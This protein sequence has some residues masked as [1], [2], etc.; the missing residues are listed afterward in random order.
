MHHFRPNIPHRAAAAPYPAAS[1]GWFLPVF[2]FAIFACTAFGA[3]PAFSAGTVEQIFIRNA[4]NS[5]IFRMDLFGKG[6]SLVYDED[7]GEPLVSKR[8]FYTNEKEDIVRGMVYWTEVLKNKGTLP[9][10][11]II[12]MGV[13]QDTDYNAAAIFF[14]DNKNRGLMLGALTGKFNVLHLAGLT[15]DPIPGGF[16]SLAFINDFTWDTQP[17]SNLPE[18]AGTL[19]PTIIHELGHALGI[20]GD[21]EAFK[22]LLSGPEHSVV[23]NGPKAMAVYGGPVPMA[24]ASDQ[25]DSH[26]GLRNGLMTHCQIPNYPMFMEAELATL[27]DIGY[28]IDLRNFFGR[29]LYGLTDANGVI[30]ADV[31]SYDAGKVIDNN[32]GFFQSKG[33]DENGNWLGYADGR[34]NTSSFGVGLHFYGSYWDVTQQAHLLA[35]GPGGAGIRMDGF[36]NTVNIPENIIISGNGERGTGLLVSFGEHHVI[37]SMGTIMATGNMGIAARFDFG[38]PYVDEKLESYG[39]YYINHQSEDSGGPM[40]WL[41]GPLVREFNL[42]GA[43]IGGPSS[44]DGQFLSGNWENFAG[45]P[46]ALY[47]G[48]SAHVAEIN[49]MNGA[50]IHGDIVSR[51][52]PYQNMNIPSG[53]EWLYMTDLTF[54]YSANIDG[55]ASPWAD[56]N[57]SLNYQGNIIGPDSLKLSHV[58]GTLRYSGQMDVLSYTMQG[59]SSKLL[60]D[61][62][63]G[64]PTSISAPDIT[65]NAGTSIGFSPATFAYGSPLPAGKAPVLSLKATTLDNQATLLNPTASGVFAIGPWEYVYRGI[66]WNADRSTLLVNTSPAAFNHERGGTDAQAAPMALFMH[67]QPLNITSNRIIRRFTQAQTGSLFSEP[68]SAASLLGK[69]P[70]SWQQFFAYGAIPGLANQQK[71]LQTRSQDQVQ[72]LALDNAGWEAKTG[73]SGT[74][75]A[76]YY[77]TTSHRGKRHYTV[78]GAGVAFGMDHQFSESFYLGAAMALDYPR[79]DSSHA[80]VRAK[81]RAGIIYG[82]LVLPCRLEL[83]FAGSMGAIDF[84]Q[85]R[86]VLGQKYETDF[87][88]QTINTALSLGRQFAISDSLVLR[89]ALGWE[90]FYMTRPSHSEG[91]G[92]YALT[93]D[94]SRTSANRLKAGLETAW[95]FGQGDIT[96]RA[97]WLGI[98]DN[99]NEKSSAHFALD[100]ARNTFQAPLDPLDKHSLELAA[101]CNYQLGE[102]IRIGLEYAIVTGERST[103]HQG[104]LGLRFEF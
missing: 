43:L 78:E 83:G 92:P 30:I 98:P 21:N 3:L 52:D 97:F 11:A 88:A 94:S 35:D 57:F 76:P 4:D 63:K 89:P 40:G 10:P 59:T 49:I 73:K 79:Y 25:E 14:A 64:L 101:N 53:D 100:P 95:T 60:V 58:G 16:H 84:E 80:K 33:L 24:H 55:S 22:L 91:T 32:T 103:T 44:P 54:G 29:S 34:P 50:S 45:R 48:P 2:F 99:T 74:W 81:S 68:Q 85:D 37:N 56:Q 31:D 69:N 66:Q 12:R 77:S 67:S 46:L 39:N 51:W 71:N 13:D 96:A 41:N 17:N 8:N 26:F 90:Y 27:I 1:P 62:D 28:S 5:P 82:G 42:S 20:I 9:G 61:F 19:G 72:W 38:A 36:Y 7:E 104:V 23:F 87:T 65:M 93:Y 15:N 6:L 47:I 86:K 70:D 102:A 18:T 75:V